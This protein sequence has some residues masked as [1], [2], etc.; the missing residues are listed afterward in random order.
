M[1]QL[2]PPSARLV[3]AYTERLKPVYNQSAESDESLLVVKRNLF[4]TSEILEV[5]ERAAD[6]LT[7]VRLR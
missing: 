1:T 7:S 4:I 3:T 5:L 6:H 2:F